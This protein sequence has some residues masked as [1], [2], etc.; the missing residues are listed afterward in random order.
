MLKNIKKMQIIIE[1]FKI[2][3]RIINKMPIAMKEI[4]LYLLAIFLT[5]SVLLAHS[6]ENV[7]LFL[8]SPK[9]IEAGQEFTVNITINKLGIN[10]FSK[11]EAVFPRGFFIEPI[12]KSGSTFIMKDNKAK[13]IWLDLPADESF[14]ISYKVTV[15][16]YYSGQEDIKGA[17][18]YVEGNEKLSQKFSSRIQII[19]NNLIKFEYIL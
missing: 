15:P 6:N 10:G 4:K 2:S 5:F 9:Q 7:S 1:T 13:F 17:F 3:G 11:F 12:E 18:Y 14:N 8:R 16:E 19:N